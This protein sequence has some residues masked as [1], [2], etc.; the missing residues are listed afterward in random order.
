VADPSRLG[1]GPPLRER[2]TEELRAWG[3]PASAW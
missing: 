1:S 2:I 3:I